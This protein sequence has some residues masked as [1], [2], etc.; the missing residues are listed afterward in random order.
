MSIYIYIYDCM[1]T[2]KNIQSSRLETFWYLSHQ[3]K[4]I[5]NVIDTFEN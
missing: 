1:Q 2:K 3:K 4:K 5:R